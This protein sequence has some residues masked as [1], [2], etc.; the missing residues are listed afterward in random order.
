MLSDL[1]ESGSIEQD[2]DVVAF[3]YREDYYNPDTDR[4]NI[5]EVLI[6]KHRNGPTG[7]VELYFDRERQKIRSLDTKHADPF[8]G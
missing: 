8:A 1:R 6:R 3:L 2:A 5:L 4:Q 7:T